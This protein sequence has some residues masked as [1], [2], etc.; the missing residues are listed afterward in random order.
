MEKPEEEPGKPKYTFLDG[1]TEKDLLKRLKEAYG[2]KLG[3]DG[4]ISVGN[5]KGVEIL[6]RPAQDGEKPFDSYIG[7]TEINAPALY[8]LMFIHSFAHRYEW[9]EMY[10]KGEDLEVFDHLL[11]KVS[12]TELKGV[13]PASGR[14][15]CNFIVL[16]ELDEGVYCQAYEAVEFAKYPEQ[17]GL[18]R[19]EI[20]LGGFVIKELSADPPKCKVSYI[21]K[22][23][24]KGYFPA[25][26]SN[27]VTMSQPK[28]VGKVREKVEAQYKKDLAAK[29]GDKSI[30]VEQAI[31][32]EKEF[33][34]LKEAKLQGSS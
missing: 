21:T 18:V 20:L 28:A 26:F 5:D 2:A 10:V 16:R 32:V 19:A 9:D 7:I 12:M 8:T 14:D 17:N 6:K 11:T 29:E 23:D 30:I 15:M 31:Y 25:S 1:E 27:K 24:L 3:K 13:W 22:V 33:K 4:W 34:R